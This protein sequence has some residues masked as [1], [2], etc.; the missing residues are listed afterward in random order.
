MTQMIRTRFAPSPTGRLHLGNARTALFSALLAA[1]EGGQFVLRIEDT[2]AAR[3]RDEHITELLEDLRW[4]GLRWDEGPDI[5]GDKGP[6]R[7]AERGGLYAEHAARLLATNQAYPCFCTTEELAAERA[8]A[9]TK[10]RAPRYSGRCARIATAEAQRRLA[11]GESAS[12][13]FRVPV[14]RELVFDDL[15]RGEQRV[16]SHTLGDFVIRRSD[17]TPAFFFANALDDALMRITHVLRGEDHLTN[18]PR[19]LLL[20]EALELDAPRYGHLPLVVDDGDKPLS[21]RNASVGLAELRE[22]GWLPLAVANYLLRLGHTPQSNEL[23][24]LDDLPAAFDSA[25]LGRASAHYDAAQMGHWQHLAIVALDADAAAAWSGVRAQRQTEFWALIRENVT[26]RNDVEAWVVALD[27]EPP[28]LGAAAEKALGEAPSELWITGM[29]LTV[30]DDF[31]AVVAAV[32]ERTGLG[33]RRLFQP[34]RAALTGRHDG[35][36]MARLWV[37]FSPAERWARFERAA[38]LTE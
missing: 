19:Q 30:E 6:Y 36:E 20:L 33:G 3:S 25:H 11:A 32:R 2:D 4:L 10:G 21:K 13:R 18:T 22:Q 7:Q 29:E 1:R 15:V 28:P 23:L 38:T 34:L 26:H 12:L 5:G 24:A 27:A 37:W 8:K 17:G 35:P 14:N 16:A 9:L 31:A